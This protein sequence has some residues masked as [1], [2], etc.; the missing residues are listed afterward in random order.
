IGAV[1]NGRSA[2]IAPSQPTLWQ[3]N[4]SASLHQALPLKPIS[5]QFPSSMPHL[6]SSEDQAPWESWP[7][8]SNGNNPSS[9]QFPALGQAQSSTDNARAPAGELPTAAKPRSGLR[10]VIQ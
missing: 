4:D 2:T 8:V 10:G 9:V 7:S 3:A 5:E 6:G 1:A